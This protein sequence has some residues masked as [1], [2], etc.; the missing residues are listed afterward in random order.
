M[1]VEI[2]TSA[3]DIH[4]SLFNI[5]IQTL[6]RSIS[7]STA[8]A[9]HTRLPAWRTTIEFGPSRTSSAMT[10]FLLTGR[11]CI[12]FALFVPLSLSLVIIHPGSVL[13]IFP[14]SLNDDQFFT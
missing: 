5:R 12:T 3:F 2:R 13:M 8:C 1:N 11:Q 10:R 6:A 14:Y 4:Y 9:A 7:L